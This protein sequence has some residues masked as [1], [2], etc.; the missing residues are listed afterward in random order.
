MANY[1]LA[2]DQGTTSSRAILFDHGGR[3]VS[4][5]QEEFPQIYPHPGWVEHDPAAIWRTQVDTAKG[6]L[7]QAGV[8]SAQV[9]AI[10]ITNQRETTV[11]WDRDTGAPLHNAIVWQCRRTADLCAQLTAA[12]LGEEFRRRTGLVVDPYFSGTKVKWVLDHVDGARERAVRGELCFGTIDSWLL[13][14]LTGRHATDHSNASRTLLYNIHDLEWDEALLGHL[15]VPPELLPEVQP[16]SAV[17]GTTSVLGGEIPV[18]ALCGDQQSA[19][20]GQAG[21]RPDDCKNT[22]GTG[23]FVLT[24]TGERSA[25]SQHGLVT[26]IAWGLGDRVEYALPMVRLLPP[27]SIA[28][29]AS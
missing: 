10:G 15:D 2:L 9:K 20:F 17:Y 14:K 11:V 16:S 3:I 5:A 4:A 13:F 18:A 28:R 26:T 6:T 27:I 29:V 23:C 8:G 24:N 25:P 7:E 21:F 12:G 1:V 19:L 22:Y